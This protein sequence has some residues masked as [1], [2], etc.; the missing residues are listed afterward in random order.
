MEVL[1][2]FARKIKIALL[3]LSLALA[4]CSSGKEGVLEVDQGFLERCLGT[5]EGAGKWDTGTGWQARLLIFGTALFAPEVLKKCRYEWDVWLFL[6]A[7]VC[8]PD[9]VY[10]A[11][12]SSG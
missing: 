4:P 7:G 9:M 6:G 11:C 3:V 2:Q 10:I 12:G 1:A 5:V 8:N